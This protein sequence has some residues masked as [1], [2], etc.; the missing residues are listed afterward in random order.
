VFN[1]RL[2]A[3]DLGVDIEFCNL[4][5]VIAK[6]SVVHPIPVEIFKKKQ[7]SFSRLDAIYRVSQ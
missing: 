6:I 2:M 4:D 7:F 1:E 5:V 3:N